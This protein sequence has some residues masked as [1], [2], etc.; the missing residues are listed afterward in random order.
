MRVFIGIKA[1]EGIQKKIS[2]WQD[3]NRSLETRFIKPE[4]LH[5]TL[6]PPWYTANINRLVKDLKSFKSSVSRF[7]IFLNN[8]STGPPNKPRLVWVQGPDLPELPKLRNELSA[9]FKRPEE[10]RPFKTHI[11]IARF[12]KKTKNIQ[13]IRETISWELTVSEIIL[14]ESLLNPKGAIYKIIGS[15]KI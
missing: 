3:L 10:K 11:T 8:I 14:F 1:S 2:E 6:L 13:A 7:N 9:H 5:L 15:V 4:N 12:G